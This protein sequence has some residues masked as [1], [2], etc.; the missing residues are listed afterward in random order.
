MKRI[1][2]TVEGELA[3]MSVEG[4]SAID[5]IG[6]LRYFQRL[7]EYRLINAHMSAERAKVKTGKKKPAKRK[8]GGR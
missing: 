4:L 8:E 5:L 1:T 2:I 6:H 7:T 3:S